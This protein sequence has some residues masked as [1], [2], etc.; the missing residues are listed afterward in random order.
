MRQIHVFPDEAVYAPGRVSA[1]VP[2]YGRKAGQLKQVLQDLSAQTA[3]DLE[4]LVVNNGIPEADLAERLADYPTVKFLHLDRNYGAAYARN[5]GAL[6]SEGEYLWFVDSDLEHIPPRTAET[7]MGLLAASPTAGCIGGVF[8]PDR[9]RCSFVGGRLR[10]DADSAEAIAIHC[11]VDQ[12]VNTACLLIPKKLFFRINGF[13]DYIEYPFD[14][15]DFGYKLTSTG[16][17]ALADTRA[18]AFHP[19]HPMK[20]SIFGEFMSMHNLLVHL[21]INYT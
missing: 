1:I 15:V 17:R 4:I 20:N 14:D 6:V 9:D 18:A 8:F 3:P 16:R 2:V 21:V 13:A 7:A 19:I 11:R 5:A 12:F 10:I